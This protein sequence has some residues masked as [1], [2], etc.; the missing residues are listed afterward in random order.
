MTRAKTIAPSAIR[1]L[2]VTACLVVWGHSLGCGGTEPQAP[3]SPDGADAASAHDSA[4]ASGPSDSADSPDASAR[5][6]A[7]FSPDASNSDAGA[8]S[9]DDASAGKCP[10]GQL[11]CPGCPGQAGGCAVGG[12]PGYAC[13]IDVP[14]GG[15]PPVTDAGDAEP[16]PS[17]GAQTCSAGALCVRPCC[18]GTEPPCTPQPEGGACPRDSDPVALCPGSAAQ[19]PGCQ[20]RPCVPPAPFCM[21]VPTSCQGT[22]QCSCVPNACTTSGTCFSVTA[23]EVQCSC[24]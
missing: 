16:P 23:S 8:I 4:N 2:K 7:S 12:C 18:G 13:L 21:P 20:Q 14:D 11:F 24:A 1:A 22:P 3:N 5:A 19:G 17:C 6:D 10:S 15:P 9:P